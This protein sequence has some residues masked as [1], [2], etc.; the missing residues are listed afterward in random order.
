MKNRAARKTHKVFLQ[1]SKQVGTR[2][3][4]Q[5]RSHHQ[6]ISKYHRSLEEIISYYEDA[7]FPAPKEQ[8][9]R[10]AAEAVET[11]FYSLRRKE[12]TFRV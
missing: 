3:A 5:C 1:M 7:L 10:T 8:L 2:T 9:W 12:N 11:E 4:D 6:K